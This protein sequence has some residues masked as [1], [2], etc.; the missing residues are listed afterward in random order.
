MVMLL[1]YTPY[2]LANFP[3]SC[4]NQPFC[5]RTNGFKQLT[6]CEILLHLSMNTVTGRSQFKAVKLYSQSHS[7]YLPCHSLSGST[8]LNPE[9]LAANSKH[10]LILL[11]FQYV[12]NEGIKNLFSVFSSAVS[13][14]FLEL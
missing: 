11:K 6:F 14:G 10:V 1:F 2:T 4:C 13:S 3:Q 7:I 8:K 12:H 9:I 5:F